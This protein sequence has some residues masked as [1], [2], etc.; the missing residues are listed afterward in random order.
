MPVRPLEERGCFQAILGMV[1]FLRVISS[2]ANFFLFEL[3]GKMTSHEL[4]FLLL[5][6]YSIFIKD[7]TT[8]TGL[9]QRQYVRIAIRNTQDNDK[10]VSALLEIDNK[11]TD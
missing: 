10:L 1:P 3:N 9:S 4:A 2:Q 6:K 11:K 7:C 5:K 8:K